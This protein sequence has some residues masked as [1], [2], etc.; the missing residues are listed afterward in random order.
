MKAR[1]PA[2]SAEA[3]LGDL[4]RASADVGDSTA[5]RKCT[6]RHRG[7]CA[8]CDVVVADKLA[9]GIAESDKRVL[10]NN[11]RGGRRLVTSLCG[12]VRPHCGVAA[13]ESC[14]AEKAHAR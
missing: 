1:R 5:C 11:A 2:A 13:V 8:Q 6:A 7:V 4:A 14:R 3:F 9:L 12:A 10:R